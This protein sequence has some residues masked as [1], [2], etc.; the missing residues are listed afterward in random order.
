MT[1]TPRPALRP[2]AAGRSRHTPRP[3]HA[4]ARARTA[5]WLLP[6]ALLPGCA[7]ASGA[8]PATH[9]GPPTD[10]PPPVHREFRG[11]WVATVA[12]I[13]WPSR[14]G[15]PADSQ[16]AELL[17]IFDRAAELG[18]NGVVF[19]VRPAGDALYDSPHEPW[20]EYLTGTMGRPPEPAY[21]P[22]A[23]AIEAAHDRGL[24]LH[25]WFNPYR[26]RH[27][28]AQSDLSPD[29]LGRTRPDLVVEYGRHLWMD[30]G[31]PEVREHSLRVI[32]DVVRRYDV[33]GVHL[34][35][36]FYPYRERDSAGVE[37]PFPDTASWARYRAD[38]GRLDRDDWRRSNVD[39]FVEEL[40]RRVRAERPHVRVGISPIGVYRPGQPPGW[41]CWDAYEGIYADAR[42]W[43]VE[44]WLD[45]FAP[46]LYRPITDSLRSYPISLGWWIEQNVKGRHLWPGM[47]PSRVR[48][49]GQVDG[50]PPEE[51]L[52]QILVTRGQPGASGHVHFNAQAL[53]RNPILTDLLAARAY[54]WPALPPTA[55]WLD[56]SPPARPRVSSQSGTPDDATLAPGSPGGLALALRPGDAEAPRWWLVQARYD[57]DWTV[58][59]VPGSRAGVRLPA[60]TV[61]D[62][63]LVSAVDRLANVGPPLRLAGPMLADGRDAAMP[64][65]HDRFAILPGP[66]SPDDAWVETTLAGLTL[67]QKVGQLMV[68]WLGGD[69]LPLDGEEYERLREWVV[70]YD[71]GGVTLAIGSPQAVAAKLNALQELAP[72]PLLVSANM[73]HG[74]GQR[75]TGGTV[76][77]YGLELGGGTAFPPLMGMGATGDE[78]LAYEMGRITAIEARAVGVHMAYGPVVDV[79]SDP[80]NPIINTRSYG[81]DPAEVA[82]LATAHIRGMQEHGVIATAK[83]FP[84][85][86]DTDIDSHIALPVIPHD[87]ARTDSVELVPFRSAIDNGVGAVMSAHIAFPSLTGDS[88]PATLQPRLL[89]GL[90]RDELG[91]DGLVVTDALGMGGIVSGW[92]GH[93]AAVLALEA[94]ADVLLMPADLPGAIDAVVAAIESG[95]IPEERLDRSVRR[96]LHAK[97]GL[98]LHRERT[99]D[100][101][102]VPGVV[103][104]EAHR[105]V[106]RQA[107]EAS[108]TLAR[109]RDGLVP[110]T[111]GDSLRIL[112]IVYTDDPDPFAGR[113]FRRELAARFPD[114]EDA[115][116]DADPGPRQL[117]AIRT[118]ADRADL[119]IFAPFVRAMASKDEI[120]IAGPVAALVRELAARHPT[121]AVSFGNPYV[122]SAFPDVGA[123]MLAWGDENA[124]QRAAVRALTGEIPIRGRLPVSIPPDLARGEG[125]ER[126]REPA[127]GD[128][129]GQAGY[130]GTR[131]PQP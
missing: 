46:Q 27:P 53:L 90:L 125:E 39:T 79:N 41:C 87:R 10:G 130:D 14:P 71:I 64:A 116:L 5:P 67:R 112:A 83:H 43:L 35:D 56:D 29:H 20:S 95:R 119:V 85:H 121:L 24:E 89:T 78:R 11:V 99:V 61:P 37:I 51:I 117:D 38:G 122:L 32:L 129:P 101:A 62:E 23:F 48:R 107:A 66:G 42:K 105:E 126:P 63:I 12:N 72:V 13:D 92:G 6:L 19:Q 104:I 110:L 4:G 58:D 76:L 73:E 16:R 33:D 50:Q 96:V 17:T 36:Y 60:D 2:L 34:D 80:G 70:D 54:R 55:P 102:R 127:P 22:L 68:P 131:T 124:L 65:A 94:G 57:A 40:Y 114:G 1:M 25:A 3:R 45:Y 91:F 82:R 8:P 59:I 120:G 31:E 84:G 111:A 69:Y 75:L 81:E 103:G 88:T 74:P 77:P 7:L 86:G 9:D 28:S 21:D 93:E 98:G 113:T 109:D 128:A 44:G 47:A 115:L 52:R 49:P 100:V 18:L 106:A 97:A 15:L 123:Y 26:A 30:P 108:I 118:M